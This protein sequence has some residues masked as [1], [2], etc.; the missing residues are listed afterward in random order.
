MSAEGAPIEE[1]R[2]NIYSQGIELRG[3]VS[4]LLQT[5]RKLR[6]RIRNSIL[7]TELRKLEEAYDQLYAE[8]VSYDSYVSSFFGIASRPARSDEEIEEGRVGTYDISRQGPLL[9]YAY[10]L[11]SQRETVRALLQDLGNLINNHEA[12]ANNI[13]ATLIAL[14][15][16]FT[17][18]T[19]SVIQLIIQLYS[20]AEV[21]ILW[22]PRQ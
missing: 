12:Q 18:V 7:R 19:L 6:L 17:T 4:K 10:N 14:A 2:E 5:A 11:S 20:A 16:L 15:A 8:F 1:L 3:K 21:H 13:C 9:I 22:L